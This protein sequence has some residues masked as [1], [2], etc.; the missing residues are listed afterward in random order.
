MT[1]HASFNGSRHAAL[2]PPGA[3]PRNQMKLQAPL[4]PSLREAQHSTAQHSTAQHSTAQHSTAQHSTA[5]HST[6]QHSTAREAASFNGF[7]ELN[8][9]PM[10]HTHGC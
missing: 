8:L 9:L 1:A 10:G 6:A 2:H 7:T 3:V 5:Q 4:F